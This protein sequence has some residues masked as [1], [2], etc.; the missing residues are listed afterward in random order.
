MTFGQEVTKY[1]EL[2][3]I[4]VSVDYKAL[5][6]AILS[7]FLEECKN[8]SRYWEHFQPDDKEQLVRSTVEEVLLKITS[9][10]RDK[11]G[12][13]ESTTIHK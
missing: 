10:I 4:C 1:E 7:I 2:S 3:F 5:C 8:Y 9:I 12:R 6:V 11:T 13:K